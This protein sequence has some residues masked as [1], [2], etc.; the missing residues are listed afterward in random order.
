LSADEWFEGAQEHV[1]SW[2]PEWAGFLAEH[3]G[4]DVKAPAKP[5]N[6]S[7]KVIEPAP[8][9]FVKVRAD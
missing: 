7:H 9:R 3:G 6:A 4:S 5:G 1:G 2:W 8:G